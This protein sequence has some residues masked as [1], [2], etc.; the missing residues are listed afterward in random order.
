MCIINV[1]VH[2]PEK[3]SEVF[4]DDVESAEMAI[5]SIVGTALLEFFDTVLVENVTVLHSSERN[6]ENEEWSNTRGCV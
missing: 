1:R 3:F 2:C 6:V 4:V 5:E